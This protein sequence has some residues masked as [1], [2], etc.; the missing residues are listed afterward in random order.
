[1]RRGTL[2]LMP[3]FFKNRVFL[4]IVVC[5]LAL[6]LV[7][8]FFVYHFAVQSEQESLVIRAQSVAAVFDSREIEQL[9]GDESDLQ[10]PAYASIKQKLIRIGHVDTDV[11]SVYVTGY[12]NGEIFFYADSVDNHEVGE[13]T[14]GLS[15]PEATPLFK[16]VFTEGRSILEGPLA[17]RWGTWVSGIAPIVDGQT[18]RVVASIGLDIDASVYRL[19]VAT[20]TLIPIL[21]LGVILLLVLIFYGQYEKKKETLALKAKFISIASHELRSP[22]AGIVWACQS[23][24]KRGA[25]QLDPSVAKTVSLIEQTGHRVISSVG[26]IM[27]LSAL[28]NV[29][30]G[31]I[32]YEQVNMTVLLADIIESLALVTAEHRIKIR[33]DAR[34]PGKLELECDREKCKRIFSNVIT[35]ALK[36]SRPDSQIVLGHESKGGMRIISVKDNGIGIPLAEQAN[37]FRGDFRA[38]NALAA[39][40]AGSGFGLH[41]VKELVEAQGGKI[42]F[43]SEINVGTTFFVALRG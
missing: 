26:D 2:G 18:N 38:S 7:F 19:G 4:L 3:R 8:G 11:T 6:E 17:D 40:V 5:S 43:E 36:Y 39:H 1:M 32:A 10:N 14:P 20:K 27:N 29:D 12:R 21:L 28:E 25:T 9:R 35:N 13:A 41:F 37:I 33:F 34:W 31:K 42:W 30:P 22:V 24:L 15:Y 23:L 16:S